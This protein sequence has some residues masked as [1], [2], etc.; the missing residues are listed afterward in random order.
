MRKLSKFLAILLSLTILLSTGVLAVLADGTDTSMGGSTGGFPA[1]EPEPTTPSVSTSSNIEITFLHGDEFTMEAQPGTTKLSDGSVLA[2]T[3]KGLFNEKLIPESTGVDQYYAVTD[4]AIKDGEELII[5]DFETYRFEKDT[6]LYAIVKDSWPLYT[7][8]KT[9]RTDWFYQYV[10]DLSIAGVVD[11]FNAGDFRPHKDLTWGQALKL[12]MLATGYE[13]Q[14]PT[15]T[16][17]ASGYLTKAK[18]DGL[19]ASD[20][21]VDLDAPIARIDVAEIAAKAMDL[22]EVDIESPF[23]DTDAMAVLQLYDAGIV[24]GNVNTAGVRN[25]HPD[26]TISRAEISAI[27]WR[28]ERYA[29]E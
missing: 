24:E 19:V 15:E 26:D 17:W 18:A 25:F 6:E 29:A 20:R 7:D 28:I 16:H 3:G 9:D 4:W 12:V 27:V 22:D 5:I 11:G 2:R 14:A 8:M 10:R 13:E 23:A 21:V 1:D